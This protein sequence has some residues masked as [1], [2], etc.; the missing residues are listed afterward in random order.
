MKKS[1]LSLI[2]VF[3]LLFSLVPPARAE[4]RT[5]EPDIETMIAEQFDA[6]VKKL[7]P[8]SSSD[9]PM[10][11]VLHA[12]AGSSD[13]HLDQDDSMT[14]TFLNSR[15][16]RAAFVDAASALCRSAGSV[17]GSEEIQMGGNLY[18]YQTQMGYRMGG[19]VTDENSNPEDDPAHVPGFYLQDLNLSGDFNSFDE[20]M[21][22]VV[23]DGRCF[24][25]FEPR[26]ITDTTVSYHVTLSI[27]D[28]FDFNNSEYYGDDQDLEKFLTW[29]GKML[30]FGIFHTFEWTATAEFDLEMPNLC[31]HISH[32]Y[33]W[34]YDGTG[35]LVSVSSEEF[36][37][38][39]LARIDGQM[40]ESGFFQKVWYTTQVPMRLCHDRPWVL[41][42]RCRG[43]GEFVLADC[44]SRRYG[45]FLRRNRNTVF[46]N[47]TKNISQNEVYLESH[48]R[49]YQETTGFLAED[50]HTFTLT[51]QVFPDGSSMVRLSVDGVDLGDMD[52]YYS[53]GVFVENQ[54]DWY[55]DRDFIYGFIGSSHHPLKGVAV[56][57]IRA[58]ENGRDQ[59]AFSYL[60][61]RE[62]SPT[63]AADGGTL[64]TC[65][66]CGAEFLTNVIPAYGHDFAEWKTVKEP[67][68]A[69]EGRMERVCKT[70][71][72]TE[73]KPIPA[74][75]HDWT[76]WAAEGA[77]D[78]TEGGIQERHCLRCGDSEKKEVAS[79]AHL[80]EARIVEP[81]CV[82]LGYT[83]YTC[84]VCGYSYKTNFTNTG[85]HSFGPWSTLRDATEQEAGL[86]ERSCTIC[87]VTEQKTIPMLKNPF[88]DVQKADY[89]YAPVLWAV[90][91]G[92]TTGTSATTFEPDSSCLRAQVVTFLW[93]A[94][95]EPE[96]SSNTNPFVDVKE[97]DYYYKAVLWAV[98]NGITNGIDGTHFGPETACSRSQ[99]V[100]FLYRAFGK[101]TVENNANP[102]TDVPSNE[103]YTAPVLWAVEKGITNGIDE[104]H[105]GPDNECSRSQIV[106]F[107]YRAYN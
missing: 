101:P 73:R 38:N 60:T 48:G 15:L 29:A 95:G 88:S 104:H 105:F 62:V 83:I 90:S 96:P 92:I 33:A 26:K 87:G 14:R 89:F 64:N 6:F 78:C 3:V 23:G 22:L 65:S 30:V 12:I 20:A 54:P 72:D 63:C 57:Y 75:G 98:E 41:E 85:D 40:D 55:K 91:R 34:E 39:P 44:S 74:L 37:R 49:N 61:A 28:K 7:K 59:E 107:L 31:P 17:F 102:F 24:F 36:A 53:R 84:A 8:G 69:E 18:W 42:F 79:T 94:A 67:G 9:G 21:F 76:D 43:T 47:T 100:T 52:R 2:L 46:F 32:N 58:W 16:L 93:R 51:N 35:D 77:W 10:E 45:T 56:E 71:G 5:A 25:T 70:C 68:C 81:T 82:D 97:S 13:L 27:Y 1:I 4:E 103:W 66:L 86:L 50:A 11:L 19:K 99:V 80:Y 106:T